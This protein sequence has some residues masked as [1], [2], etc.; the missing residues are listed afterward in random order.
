MH[1]GSSTD[2]VCLLWVP[3]FLQEHTKS[4]PNASDNHSNHATHTA[5]LHTPCWHLVS[6][7]SATRRARTRQCAHPPHACAPSYPPHA[8]PLLHAWTGRCMR[9]PCGTPPLLPGEPAWKC[10]VVLT[11]C[12]IC[13][14]AACIK[15][16]ALERHANRQ[17][18]HTNVSPP[19]VSV[20]T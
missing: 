16:T 13:T 10:S 1:A 19:G 5:L 6:P 14:V 8:R 3:H 7:C 18:D 2:L 4:P 11:A 20:Q 15:A 9:G 17:H 12:V